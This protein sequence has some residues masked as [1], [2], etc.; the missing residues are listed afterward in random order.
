MSQGRYQTQHC[1]QYAYCKG[2]GENRCVRFDAHDALFQGVLEN[3]KKIQYKNMSAVL[4]GQLLGKA[5]SFAQIHHVSMDTAI[6]KLL[7]V[8]LSLG[9]KGNKR[10][11]MCLPPSKRNIKKLTQNSGHYAQNFCRAWRVVKGYGQTSTSACPRR[12]STNHIPLFNDTA[13]ST[14]GMFLPNVALTPEAD[15]VVQR[16]N[17]REHNAIKTVDGKQYLSGCTKLDKQRLKYFFNP[18]FLAEMLAKL[19]DKSVEY[20]RRTSN[21]P[22]RTRNARRRNSADGPEE[23]KKQKTMRR[24]SF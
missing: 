1:H 19:I 7:T 17:E 10:P 9:C 12:G 21:L 5:R 8:E 22:K 18:N 13:L 3:P 20:V 6:K 14:I 2:R 11:R 16:L 24:R 15:D 4:A 23:H